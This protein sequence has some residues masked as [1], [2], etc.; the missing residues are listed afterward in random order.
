MMLFLCL[1]F[2]FQNSFFGAMPKRK[3]RGRPKG[4]HVQKEVKE[5]ADGEFA[6]PNIPLNG[7]KADPDFIEEQEGGTHRLTSY[8]PFL[9]VFC[10][11]C[12]CCE[13]HMLTVVIIYQLCDS[14]SILPR[15][16]GRGRPKGSRAQN[17]QVH[18]NLN[19]RINPSNMV[20]VAPGCEEP[21]DEGMFLW[22]Q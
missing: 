22:L 15:K 6:I 16:K 1:I 5:S 20:E 18:G 10:S 12:F 8:I 11:L 17:C 7:L 4:S 19:S 9:F 3:G 14:G 13:N 21:E 2:L